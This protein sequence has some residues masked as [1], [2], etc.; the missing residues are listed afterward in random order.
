MQISKNT[1]TILIVILIVFIYTFLNAYRGL[2]IQKNLMQ[3]QFFQIQEHHNECLDRLYKAR[4]IN[5]R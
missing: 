3:S 1:I 2:K 4:E 5:K